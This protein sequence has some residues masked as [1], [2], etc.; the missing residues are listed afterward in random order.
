MNTRRRPVVRIPIQAHEG[1]EQQSA[2]QS[3]GIERAWI[4]ERARRWFMQQLGVDHHDE[5]G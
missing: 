1:V 2:Q 3:L 4:H 5:F